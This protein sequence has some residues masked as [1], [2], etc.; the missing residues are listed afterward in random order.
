MVSCMHAVH[1]RCWHGKW[2]Q[3]ARDVGTASC[4]AYNSALQDLHSAMCNNMEHTELSKDQSSLG[5]V[6]WGAC[7]E[8]LH[9][10]VEWEV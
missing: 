9:A 3:A 4:H 2:L 6:Q 1:F 5:Y 7:T 10:A 8:E